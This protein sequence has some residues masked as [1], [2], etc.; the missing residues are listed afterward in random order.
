[1]IKVLIVDDDQ[2][3]INVITAF[4]KKI[5]GYNI[6]K[7]CNNGAA[8][9]DYLE[10]NKVDLILVDVI[11]P[12]MNGLTLVKK[13]RENLNYADIIFITAMNNTEV[14]KN[15]LKY[16]ALDYIIKPFGFDR[17]LCAMQNYKVRFIQ[18]SKTRSVNQYEIDNIINKSNDSTFR[19]LLPKGINQI[20]L[21]NI[22]EVLETITEEFTI[23]DLLK[24]IDMS[25]VSLRNYLR[26]LIQEGIIKTEIQRGSVGRPQYLYKMIS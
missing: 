21:N 19:S 4:F 2:I 10:D 17:F 22:L 24:K 1:M 11:M 6:V 14:V 26:F 9:L 18:L 12:G 7:V 20:T 23:E 25:K 13:I 3:I 8:A 5:D 15:A 16:G